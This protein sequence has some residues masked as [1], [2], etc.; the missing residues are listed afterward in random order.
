MAGK[1]R[2]QWEENEKTTDN[3]ASGDYALG[4]DETGRIKM[5]TFTGSNPGFTNGNKEVWSL[6]EQIGGRFQVNDGQF[7]QGVAN[8]VWPTDQKSLLCFL[9]WATQ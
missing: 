8:I 1:G 2:I 4:G 6:T 5:K 3:Q 7:W 9:M